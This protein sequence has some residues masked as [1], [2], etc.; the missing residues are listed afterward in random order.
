MKTR[1]NIKGLTLHELREFVDSIGE[2]PYRARQLFRWM[3]GRGAQSFEEMTDLSKPLR[4]ALEQAALV[5]NLESSMQRQSMQDGTAKF[6][7][8]LSDGLQIESVLIPPD[9]T[10]PGAEK[11]L[12]SPREKSSTRFFRRS[13]SARA[14]SPTSCTWGW[15]NPC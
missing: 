5:R 9:K 8:R 1:R 15:G 6:L 11:R 14:A 12:T 13:G 3:Y 2:K 4:T 7:F 10:S